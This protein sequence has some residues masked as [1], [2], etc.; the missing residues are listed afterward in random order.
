MKRFLIA[1]VTLVI[2]LAAIIVGITLFL[3]KND[4]Q[5]CGDIPD[6]ARQQCAAADAIVAVSGGDTSAR[7]AEA[8][9]LYKNNWAHKLVFSGAAADKTGPSNARAMKR[10]AIVAGVPASNI[11]IEETSE[12]TAENASQTVRLLKQKQTS[13]YHSRRVSIEF[14]KAAPNILTRSHPVVTDN[15]WSNMWWTT[16]IGWQLALQELVKIMGVAAE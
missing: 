6:A 4:L 14:T 11:L 7:T 5:V 15:Q 8:V 13:A 3:S 12:T 10:Q 9:R 16:V 1:I 2:I